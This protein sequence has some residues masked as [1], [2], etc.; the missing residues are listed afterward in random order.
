MNPFLL[1]L[2]TAFTLLGQ[3]GFAQS[4]FPSHL[5][6]HQLDQTQGLSNQFNAYFGVAESG[7]FWTSS[8][9]GI[10][11]FD[12]Q[13]VRTFRPQVN[14]QPLDPNITSRVFTDERANCWFTSQTALLMHRPGS[15]SLEVFQL[16]DQTHASYQLFHLE[17]GHLLWVIVD[18]YLYKVD[19]SRA[20][21]Q[22]EAQHPLGG[23]IV[24]PILDSLENVIGVSRSMITETGGLEIVR[25]HADRPM[26]RDTF[27]HGKGQPRLPSLLYYHIESPRSFWLP[28]ERGLIHFDPQQPEAYKTYRHDQN[29]KKFSYKGIA[30]WRNQYLWIGDVVSGIRLF[31]KKKKQ[32][33]DHLSHFNTTA[34]IVPPGTLN[35]LTIDKDVLWLAY[36]EYGFLYTKLGN[37]KFDQL[38]PLS[39]LKEHPALEVRKMVS[40]AEGYYILI[41]KQGIVHLKENGSITRLSFPFCRNEDIATLFLDSDQELWIVTDGD[42]YLWNTKRNQL[43]A[44][45]SCSS[46]TYEVEELSNGQFLV[47]EINRASILDKNALPNSTDQANF[48]FPEISLAAQSF[49]LPQYD[50][51]GISLNDGSLRRFQASPPYEELPPL[52]GLGYINSVVGS[53]ISR[54][55]WMASSNGLFSYQPEKNLLQ[56]IIDQD[57]W[58]NRSLSAVVEDTEGSLWLSTYSGLIRYHPDQQRADYFTESDGLYTMQY[59]E[60]IV[61]TTTHGRLLFGGNNGVTVVDP[62]RVRLNA[63][64]PDIYLHNISIAGKAQPTRPFLAKAVKALPYPKNQLSFEYAVLEYADP[65]NNR[66]QAYLI[67]NQQDTIYRGSNTSIDLPKLQEGKYQLHS[68]AYNS[69]GIGTTAAHEI[70]FTILPPWYRT[71]WARLLGFLAIAAAFYAWYRY[72]IR[73]I[74][75]RETFKRK[76]AEFRQKEAEYKQL[77]AETETAV[78]RLQMNPHFIFNSMNSI[79]RYIIER[80]IDSA[81]AYLD[82]FA[83]LMR[84]TLELSA[85]PLITIEEEIEFLELYLQ[86]ESRRLSQPLAYHFD[87]GP[88][89]DPEDTLV[90][91]MILQPFVENAIW[92]GLSPKKAAGHITIGLE[93][94]DR[95]LHCTVSDDGVG[96]AYHQGKSRR[97]QPSKAIE[98]THRR[99]ELLN[100]QFDTRTD[101]HLEDLHPDSAYPGTRVEIKLPIIE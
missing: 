60:N 73:Q 36:S 94:K 88:E 30:P 16:N 92:H 70:H 64:Q 50:Q 21:P 82:Q 32:F 87:I 67:K 79:N 101:I 78:L 45:L 98:I 80:D 63:N 61:E 53:K 68:Y 1:Y 48:Q 55:I 17:K 40:A 90:P 43:S 39:F 49:Y 44:H 93:L 100:S 13:R 62:T 83:R 27:F 19:I 5:Y 2:M 65:E 85:Q 10:N 12:G 95:Q 41:K 96:R 15:D 31:D 26:S 9:D 46:L 24:Y 14:G 57:K 28:S 37:S 74:E 25:Y 51:I 58:L 35:N 29:L 18:G 54:R 4:Q 3:A 77:V 75:K 42:I 71:W 11:Q 22:W 52:S 66:F 76:E 84:L 81:S 72:R 97:P 89:I 91:T 47:L 33:T 38:F 59:E 34:G 56:R 20:V 6:F 86:T 69:D 8:R 99:L 23:F 7:L